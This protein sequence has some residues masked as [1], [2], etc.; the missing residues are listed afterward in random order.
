VRR[1]G[2]LEPEDDVPADPRLQ[3]AGVAESKPP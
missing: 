1:S 2:E 3:G